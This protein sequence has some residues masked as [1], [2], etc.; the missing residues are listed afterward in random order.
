MSRRVEREGFGQMQKFGEAMQA[1]VVIVEG[2]AVLA[3]RLHWVAAAENGE[4]VRRGFL[5][6]TR[7]EACR[8]RF[9]AHGE[10]LAGFAAR[11]VDAPVAYIGTP[12]K[13]EV[14]ERHAPCAETKEIKVA[15]KCQTAPTAE[16]GIEERAEHIGRY[17]P[18]ARTFHAGIHPAEGVARHSQP[19]LHRLIVGRTQRAQVKRHGVVRQ[20]LPRKV[21]LVCRRPLCR[22]RIERQAVPL[23]KEIE[24][25]QGAA[26]VHCSA[27]TVLTCKLLDLLFHKFL[28]AHKRLQRRLIFHLWFYERFR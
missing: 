12:Q 8:Q 20:S 23:G 7:H 14:D 16:V 11:V 3:V 22:D 15:G 19:A 4:N 21:C 1:A 17:C 27:V 28:H 26:V 18:L 9:H 2:H 5:G 25:A 13:G 24:A 10:R 6:I